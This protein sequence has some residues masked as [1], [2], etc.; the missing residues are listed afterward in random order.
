MSSAPGRLRHEDHPDNL[1]DGEAG[2]DENHE[3]PVAVR[4]ESV[5][6]AEGDEDAEGDGELVEH[7]EPA[8]VRRGSHLGDVEGSDAAGDAD[9]DACCGVASEEMR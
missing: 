8:A 9:G 7:D 2:G 6:D 3:L 5:A 4:S 1:E